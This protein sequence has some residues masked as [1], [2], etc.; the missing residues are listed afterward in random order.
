MPAADRPDPVERVC[1]FLLALNL[2]WTT[3]CLG[4]YRPETMVVTSMLTGTTLTGWLLW[5]ALKAPARKLHPAGWWILPFVA[6]AAINAWRVTPVPWLGWHDWL[7]WAQMAAIFWLGLNAM[8]STWSRAALLITLAAMGLVAVVLA[9]YQHFV[10]PD[11]LMLG[12]QQSD[13]FIGRSSGPFGIPNSL[14]ALLLLLLPATWALALRRGAPATQRILFGYFGLVYLYGLFLTVSRGAWL[15][16]G[17]ALCLW[18][19]VGLRWAWWKRLAGAAVVAFGCLA[20]GWGLYR[21]V[22][23][24]HERLAQMRAESGEWTRPI[25]WHGAW[26]LFREHPWFGSGAGSYNVLFEKYRPEKYQLEP[27]W[28]HNDYL[29]TLSDYGTTGFVLLF[30]A[31]LGLAA[32]TMRRSR[33]EA[34]APV[35]RFGALLHEPWLWRGLAVGLLA[36]AFQLTVDFHFKIPALAAIF[37]VIGAL[38]IG[39]RHPAAMMKLGPRRVAWSRIASA[40]AATGVGLVFLGL[41]LP[42]YRAEASRYSARQAMDKLW[43]VDEQSA[44]YRLT[45]R[46]CNTK[47]MRA[48]R[49][50]PTNAQ[51][52]ADLSYATTLQARIGPG[53]AHAVLGREAEE[54]ANRA[55]AL[56]TVVPEFWIRRAIA[57]DMQGQWLPAGND[58]VKAVQ[59]APASAPVWYYQ[60]YH[61]SL[62]PSGLALAR[63]AVAYCLRLDPSYHTAQLLRQQL[64][65]K[66]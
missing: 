41:A 36:F 42:H 64:A 60:A 54:Y 48:V 10:R 6:Y 5:R 43:Q 23:L 57:R 15:A 8:P 40:L 31:M 34:V 50:D 52:W 3:L 25:M 46:Q 66:H 14:G 59:L 62:Q 32:W 4:G 45:L 55:L 61:Y 51:A 18:P 53:H 33:R 1:V 65:T 29:N 35:A 47:L 20:V 16:L 58:M 44:V 9:A 17:L 30:G 56:S 12:R 28:A 24:V 21:T 38:L 27:Q 39:E 37:A 26:R 49:I 7:W 2:I 13:Q 19:L 63:S 22:P 11:W